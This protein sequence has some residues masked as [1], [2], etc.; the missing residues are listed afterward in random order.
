MRKWLSS[1]AV[2]AVVAVLGIEAWL[3]LGANQL[4][5]GHQNEYLH[6]GNAM[7]LWGALIEGDW[8]HLDYYGAA[9]YWP[10]GFYVAPWPA[11]AVFGPTHA[12]MVLTNLGHLALLAWSTVALGT[13]LSGQRTGLMALACFRSTPAC[14]ATWSATSPTSP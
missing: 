3:W 14:S 4:P 13:A 9:N 1:I 11:F 7:D 12:A 2:V 6:V 5:D 8:W 10:P